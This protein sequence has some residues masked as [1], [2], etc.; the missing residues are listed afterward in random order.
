M[1]FYNYYLF[2]VCWIAG[3]MFVS[4]SL[5]L[6][7]SCNVL[8]GP[9]HNAYTRFCFQ[10][11]YFFSIAY[12]FRLIDA[13]FE[14]YIP[15]KLRFRSSSHTLIMLIFLWYSS[16]N[17]IGHILA[18][19]TLKTKIHI[20]QTQTPTWNQWTFFDIFHFS[21]CSGKKIQHKQISIAIKR[22][23]GLNEQN[24]SIKTIV[25]IVIIKSYRIIIVIYH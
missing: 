10:N 15:H 22:N 21:N 14:W 20:S 6:G 16:L 11:V 19:K 3:S 7:V 17:Y 18:I 23:H 4:H 8:P 2:T 1:R 13:L 9:F 24:I 5:T 12:T 25:I